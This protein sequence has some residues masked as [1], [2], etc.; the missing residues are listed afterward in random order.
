[1]EWSVRLS[2]Q[3]KDELIV[4]MYS[5]SIANIPDL[6]LGPCYAVQFLTQGE[7][8][9][10]VNQNRYLLQ[11]P[12]GHFVMTDHQTRLIKAGD[13]CEIYGYAFAPQYGEELHLNI[14][15]SVL[16]RLYTRPVWDI[17][18]ERMQSIIRYFELLK[19]VIPSE[20]R[21]VI[22]HLMRSFHYF[23]ATDF[24]Q[25]TYQRVPLTRAE[26]IAGRFLS[27]VEKECRNHHNIDWYSSEMCLTTK[28]VANVVKQVTGKPAGK[29]IDEAIMRQACSL[30][31]TTPLSIQELSN[32][33][34]FKN[35]SH[36][37]TFFRREAGIS[38]KAYR[39]QH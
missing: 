9:V 14:P 31:Q 28:Y 34:G 13:Y 37:G 17:D 36:F 6:F 21:P 12:C 23:L 15:R 2:G 29:C 39:M 8:L 1:M 24:S 33:L 7:L 19:D 32:K 16:A 10:E 26:E 5:G 20:N 4:G 27:M 30:L 35:Q 38:P 22:S 25:D 3:L 11:A 18:K